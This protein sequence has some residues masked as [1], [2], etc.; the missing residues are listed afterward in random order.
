MSLCYCRAPMKPGRCLYSHFV[1]GSP[2]LAPAG[3][4]VDSYTITCLQYQGL[5]QFYC[6]VLRLYKHKNDVTIPHGFLPGSYSYELMPVR[7]PWLHEFLSELCLGNVVCPPERHPSQFCFAETA[8][9]IAQ[10]CH[11]CLNPSA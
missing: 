8:P 4:L 5:G 9:C 6:L 2:L 3:C 10:A 1:V 7:C 11:K